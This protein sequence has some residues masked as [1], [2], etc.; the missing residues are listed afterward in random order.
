VAAPAH[1]FQQALQRQQ[2]ESAE[3]AK[4]R[5]ELAEFLALVGSRPGEA[6]GPEKGSSDFSFGASQ[7]ETRHY[8]RSQFCRRTT[9][10]WRIP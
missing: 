9:G 8:A 1:E 10:A 7:R 3:V 4:L 2:Q 6:S 5:Q